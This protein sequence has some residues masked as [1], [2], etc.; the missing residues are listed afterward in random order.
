MSNEPK[1]GDVLWRIPCSAVEKDGVIHYTNVTWG[2]VEFKDDDDRLARS[3]LKNQKMMLMRDLREDETTG[4]LVSYFENL[5]EERVVTYPNGLVAKVR[6]L[7]ERIV[8]EP[9]NRSTD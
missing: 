9:Y 8:F 6:E 3:W 4:E 2:H 7:K 5:S 1:V